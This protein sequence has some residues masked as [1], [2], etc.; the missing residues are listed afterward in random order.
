MAKVE[1]P[2]IVEIHDE[3]DHTSD[4]SSEE[5]THGT[6]QGSSFSRSRTNKVEKKNKKIIQKMGLKPTNEFEKIIIK[7]AKGL[8]FNILNPEVYVVPSTNNYIV[9]GEAKLEERDT[10]SQAAALANATSQ[11]EQ[12]LAAMKVNEEQTNRMSE[13]QDRQEDSEIDETDVDPA[14]IDLVIG[15]TS[16]SRVQAVKAL[17]ANN[18]DVVE[19]ILSLSP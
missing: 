19:A 9:F 6:S 3:D 10:A 11:L 2:K 13:T 16:C 8:S 12:K 5:D 17:K 14:N 7:G 4:T 15:Q 1:E 18:N